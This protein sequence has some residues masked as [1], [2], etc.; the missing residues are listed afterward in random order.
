M[1]IVSSIV[2][3]RLFI[4]A[5]K[6][7]CVGIFIFDPSNGTELDLYADRE[8]IVSQGV[9]ETPKLLL[10]GGIG[11][12]A[13]LTQHGIKMVVDSPHVGKHLLDHPIVPFVLRPKDVYA[14]DDHLLR[15]GPSNEAAFASYRRDKTGP[16]ASGLLELVGFPQ[17]DERL[18][19]YPAYRETKAVKGG[20]DHFGPG[21]RSHFEPDFV[22]MFN[23]A[24]QW[25]YPVPKEGSYMTVIVDLLR[26]V[27]EGGQVTLNSAN[28]LVDPNINL[29][30]FANDLDILAM[31]EG[32]DGRMISP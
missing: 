30:F 26:P 8:F 5:A 21:G 15:A 27:S 1:T 11:P 29:N 31:R 6:N 4:D 32:I 13:E 25:H 17:I 22:G 20:I 3:K 24:F 19:K 9:F 14:P 2:T 18:K 7:T 12:A 28:P 16:A 23:T 10:L